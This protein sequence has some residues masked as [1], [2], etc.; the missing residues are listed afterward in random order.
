M[1]GYGSGRPQ[2]RPGAAESLALP[3]SYPAA[4]LRELREKRAEGWEVAELPRLMS[5]TRGTARAPAGS[6][7]Y[8]V[9]EDA[10]G[11]PWVELRYSADGVPVR[12]R[13]QLVERPSNLPGNAGAVVYWRCACG[14]LARV[15]YA[16][17]DRWRCRRCTGVVYASSRESDR[18][19]SRILQGV[20]TDLADDAEALGIDLGRLG[21]AQLAAQLRGSTAALLL[22]LK[23]LDKMGRGIGPG[24]AR[25]GRWHGSAGR[26]RPR[27]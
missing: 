11:G 15:L 12:D 3:V 23:A 26:P 2:T 20:F 7:L 10:P 14:E 4:V 19:V 13:L 21:A 17:R 5:W 8:A 6:T 1:G 9:G 16:P 18:R 27:H 25:G 24:R 22:G